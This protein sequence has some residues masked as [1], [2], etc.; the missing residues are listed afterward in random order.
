MARSPGSEVAV[1]PAGTGDGRGAYLCRDDP[2]C[3]AA[4]PA[5]LG[6]ALGLGE[7]DLARLATEIETEMGTT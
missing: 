1:D 3:R 4:G 2:G 6:R 5:A 7:R